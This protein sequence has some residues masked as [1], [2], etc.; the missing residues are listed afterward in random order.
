MIYRQDRIPIQY[1]G[2]GDLV[3]A[4]CNFVS[5]ILMSPNLFSTL[6]NAAPGSNDVTGGAVIYTILSPHVSSTTHIPAIK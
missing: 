5:V 6:T 2:S 3:L 4:L 1:C